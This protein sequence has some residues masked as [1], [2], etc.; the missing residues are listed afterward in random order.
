MI[1]TIVIHAI[2]FVGALVSGAFSVRRIV[3]HPDRKAYWVLFVLD[4]LLVL[5]CCASFVLQIVFSGASK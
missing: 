3:E 4:F 5:L 1:M 2:W